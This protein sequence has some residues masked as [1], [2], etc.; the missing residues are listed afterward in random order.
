MKVEYLRAWEDGHWDTET[1]DVPDED[2]ERLKYP[3]TAGDDAETL[4][5]WAGLNLAPQ[6]QYRRVV[7]WAV[8][9]LPE[10]A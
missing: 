6:T 3:D 5:K 4:T 8:Y 9:S 1:H 7:L 2:I 10:T